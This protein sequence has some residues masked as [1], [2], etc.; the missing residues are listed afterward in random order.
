ML[1]YMFLPG[2]TSRRVAVTAKPSHV[3]PAPK[4]PDEALPIEGRF[5]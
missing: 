2:K 3:K 4:L 5:E 1:V